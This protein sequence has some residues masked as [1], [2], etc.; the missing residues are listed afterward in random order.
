VV[1][2]FESDPRDYAIMPAMKVSARAVMLERM[3]AVEYTFGVFYKKMFD[4]LGALN[5]LPG[6]FSIYRRACLKRS[7]SFITRTTPRTWRSPSAC[8]PTGSRS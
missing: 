6:P 1:K 2:K 5:V 7:G 4:N 8:M 3:Q